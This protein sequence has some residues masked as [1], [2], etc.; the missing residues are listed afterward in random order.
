[1][2]ESAG[3]VIIYDNKILLI[4][5]TGQKWYETYSI[6][7]GH[8]EEGEDYLDAA[9]RETTEE[10]GVRIPTNQIDFS[11]D[12]YI[13]YKTDKGETYKKVYY[14]PVYLTEPITIDKTKLQKEEIDWAGFL[15]K[16]EA[17]KRIF[18][19]F[20]PLLKYL[21]KPMKK[22]VKENLNEGRRAHPGNVMQKMLKDMVK[23]GRVTEE[24]MNHIM[25][26]AREWANDQ[27]HYGARHGYEK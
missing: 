22:L 6:P 12:K 8:V 24:E 11:E 19:R 18:W 4:H 5:P 15:N 17:E 20:K 16:E 14:Y 7:K 10:I 26:L 23:E 25:G 3:L 27:F 2:T 1:M 9:I 13:E 21:D